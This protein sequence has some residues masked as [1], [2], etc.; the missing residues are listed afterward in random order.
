M[1][2][3][4]INLGLFGYCAMLTSG[5]AVLF[6]EERLVVGGICIMCGVACGA[7]WIVRNK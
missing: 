3:T 4:M 2:D 5:G 7:A 6:G 1:K